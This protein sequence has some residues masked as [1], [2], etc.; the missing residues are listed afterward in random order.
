[1]T[2]TD[3]VL[4]HL[5]RNGSITQMEATNEYGCTRL[6]ARIKELREAGH[7][8]DRKMETAPNRYGRK[9]SY[10]RYMMPQE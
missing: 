10:A 5:K 6:S 8:I 3:M 1:M 2:Q 9:I 7:K 4:D